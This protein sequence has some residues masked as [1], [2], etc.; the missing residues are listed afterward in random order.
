MTMIAPLPNC[1]WSRL[2]AKYVRENQ[3]ET[4]K[5]SVHVARY[6][7]ICCKCSDWRDETVKIGKNYYCQRHIKV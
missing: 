4:I 1:E 6:E 5:S 2:N 7:R 3:V